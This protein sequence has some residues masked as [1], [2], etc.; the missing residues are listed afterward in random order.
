MLA[1]QAFNVVLHPHRVTGALPGDRGVVLGRAA[2][3]RG[4]SDTGERVERLEQ[5]HRGVLL[6]IDPGP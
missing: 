1:Y 4:S 2:A 5:D 6:L 3:V